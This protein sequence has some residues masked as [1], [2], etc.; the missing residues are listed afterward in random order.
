MPTCCR[1]FLGEVLQW[2]DS[3]LALKC[4]NHTC[5]L[6]LAQLD[7]G[8]GKAAPVGNGLEQ[9]PGSIIQLLLKQ[10]A[11]GAYMGVQIKKRL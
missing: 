3:A 10:P 9:N 11:W 1:N 4:K 2:C 6:E 5:L 8:G 7:K